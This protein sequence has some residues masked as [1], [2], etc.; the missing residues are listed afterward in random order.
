MN[1]EPACVVGHFNTD[2]LP[3]S[4]DA[5]DRAICDYYSR[6]LMLLIVA[7]VGPDGKPRSPNARVIERALA[8]V[9]KLSGPL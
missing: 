7:C 6:Q 4:L 2:T 1:H 9:S 8:C 5:R 3:P